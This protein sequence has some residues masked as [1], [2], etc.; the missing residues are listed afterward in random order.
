MAWNKES[1]ASRRARVAKQ[2]RD[3]HGKWIEMGGGVKWFKNGAWHNGTASAFKGNNVEVTMEDGS[4]VLVNHREIEPIRA[5][6]SL[7]EKPAKPTGSVQAKK[8][9]GKAATETMS[10]KDNDPGKRLTT[11]ADELEE[12]DEVYLHG[13]SKQSGSYGIKDSDAAAFEDRGFTL[14]LDGKGEPHR[15]RVVDTSGDKV[16]VEDS[17]GKRHEIDKNDNV[18]ADDPEVDAAIQNRD[19]NDDVPDDVDDFDVKSVDPKELGVPKEAVAAYNKGV[20]A[21]KTGDLEKAEKNFEARNGEEFSDDFTLGYLDGPHIEDRARDK[22][23]GLYHKY[24]AMKARGEK[25]AE[26]K[27]EVPVE[28]PKAEVPAKPQ[29][30]DLP[31]D[32]L[33]LTDAEKKSIND[34]ETGDEA[35]K[36][37]TESD[38]G[39]Y[40][41][42]ARSNKNKPFVDAY[43]K[44]IKD[45]TA[46]HE[47]AKDDEAPAK[48][49]KKSEGTPMEA[50]EKSMANLAEDI[51]DIKNQKLEKE[52]E[53]A[54]LAEAA[55]DVKND[56][57]EEFLL[58]AK[59]GEEEDEW[60][61]DVTDSKGN[62]V[63]TLPLEDQKPQD[64]AKAIKNSI[65]SKST[66]KDSEEPTEAPE[67]PAEK[68]VEESKEEEAP[69]TDDKSEEKDDSPLGKA[70]KDA[71]FTEDDIKK[72]ENAKDETEAEKEFF[73]SPSGKKAS[74]KQ[75]ADK[76]T[77]PEYAEARKAFE[78]FKNEKFPTGKAESDEKVKQNQEER[79]RDDKNASPEARADRAKSSI[80]RNRERDAERAAE[81][82]P[83]KKIAA[84]DR[85]IQIGEN[86]LKDAEK[87]GNEPL[88]ERLRENIDNLKE[89][90]EKLAPKDEAPAEAEAEESNTPAV[91]EPF[92]VPEGGVSILSNKKLERKTADRM[93]EGDTFFGQQNEKGDFAPV[94]ATQLRMQ[95]GAKPYTLKSVDSSTKETKWVA[96][97]SEGNEE[98][99]TWGVGQRKSHIISDSEKNRELMG[100]TRKSDKPAE[101]APASEES[102]AVEDDERVDHVDENGDVFLKDG[103]SFGSI[104][105]EEDDDGKEFMADLGSVEG[106]IFRS[107]GYYID[108][109][110]D[111]NVDGADLFTP[112]G[113]KI[114]SFMGSN[115]M[116]DDIDELADTH[117]DGNKLPDTEPVKRAKGESSS[118]ETPAEEPE[119]PK[120][121]S[122]G[123][124]MEDVETSVSDVENTLRG[125]QDR[126]N[127]DKSVIKDPEKI[128][129]RYGPSV[130]P[131]S[132]NTV[133]LVMHDGKRS[134]EVADKD[135]NV[136]GHVT[137]SGNPSDNSQD[138]LDISN[139]KNSSNEASEEKDPEEEKLAEDAEQEIDQQLETEEGSPGTADPNVKSTIGEA[140][141]DIKDDLGD[142]SWEDL[143]E[144]TWPVVG[145]EEDLF[146]GI[147][148]ESTEDDQFLGLYDSDDNELETYDMKGLV[149]DIDER[150][151]DGGDRRERDDS[152]GGELD[153]GDGSADGGDSGD[154]E[155]GGGD[156]VDP[157]EYDRQA[158]S[159]VRAVKKDLV[160]DGDNVQLD[161]EYSAEYEVDDSGNGRYRLYDSTGRTLVKIARKNEDR[162]GEILRGYSDADRE[163]HRAFATEAGSEDRKVTPTRQMQKMSSV[164]TYFENDK[165]DRYTKLNGGAW[166]MSRAGDNSDNKTMG[167]IEGHGR[168]GTSGEFT[169]GHHADHHR[170]A[171][172]IEAMSDD[173]LR[174]NLADFADRLHKIIEVDGKIGDKQ[175]SGSYAQGVRDQEAMQIYRYEAYR[176]H[177]EASDYSNALWQRLRESGAHKDG[178][179]DIGEFTPATGREPHTNKVG[180]LDDDLWTKL[181]N[182][183]VGL[184]H[185]TL[186]NNFELRSSEKPSRGAIAWGNKIDKWASSGE[187]ADDYVMYRSILASPDA[188]T[189]F[190][191]GNIV[192]D[193]GVMSLADN[194]ET[195]EH[196][197]GARTKRTA[198]KIPIMVEVQGRKGEKMT[199]A[200]FGSDELVVPRGSRMFIAS[201][202]MGEDGI[203]RVTARLNPSEA[204]VAEWTNGATSKGSD[205]PTEAPDAPEST[206]KPLTKLSPKAS[207]AET[208]AFAEE[209]WEERA[210]LTP[211]R[212]KK[213]EIVEKAT[214]DLELEQLDAEERGD[215][216]E[217]NKIEAEI[218]ALRSDLQDEVI[219]NRAERIAGGKVA[220]KSTEAELPADEPSTPVG[221]AP[222]DTPDTLPSEGMEFAKGQV[223]EHAKHGR[224]TIVRVE[225]NGEYARVNF[226]KYD[227]PKKTFGINLKKLTQTGETATL[228]NGPE[229]DTKVKFPDSSEAKVGAWSVGERV[230][231]GKHGAGVIQRLEG[232][233]EFARV[234]FDKDGDP[235]RTY[236][237]KLSKLGKGDTGTPPNGKDPSTKVDGTE[238]P[239]DKVNSGSTKTRN[240]QKNADGEEFIFG[241]NEAELYVGAVVIHP[242]FGRGRVVKLEGNGKY[243]RVIFDNDPTGIPRGIVGAKLQDESIEQEVDRSGFVPENLKKK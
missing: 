131:N 151:R 31:L 63:D 228:P 26:S 113:E 15:A 195:A 227:D 193:K 233:G 57:G 34:A 165:G 29:G 39:Q 128:R 215:F 12:G 204:E 178:A 68:P 1:K 87:K 8:S 98:E 23:Q 73:Q 176:L 28:E 97:D 202:E 54:A 41:P 10:I 65:E 158:D 81:N 220:P 59:R 17:N 206:L 183:Y 140:L 61:L 32:G 221:D 11:N 138:V 6:G 106:K 191:A 238:K 95:P 66:S 101:E 123:K 139:G 184:D 156:R 48:E 42:I 234:A 189:E 45:I 89:Q 62:V 223:V 205:A 163:L 169:L 104:P 88:A 180:P 36:R 4:K 222:S 84:L 237:V 201:S 216:V 55:Y 133:D 203:L 5:K 107:D 111:P 52:P 217:A 21:S 24:A 141:Q 117:K 64:F 118:D 115:S 181:R 231:H 103:E 148:K 240:V 171:S 35:L 80:E 25:P 164:G 33:D 173:E 230:N 175:G 208:Q 162:L 38:A 7:G 229:T 159:L 44:A 50:I 70:L 235:K 209:Y 194:R 239:K 190:S 71:G 130:I 199:A 224:G 91:G 102:M 167:V 93:K 207:N 19:D 213:F 219:A 143:K 135:G 134:W 144:R 94:K 145:A 99:F 16:V 226:D 147:G 188:A 192:T 212:A 160:D 124:P 86:F 13:R 67:T 177:D 243:A 109:P 78:D 69:K 83:E 214:E 74:D 112:D 114:G 174:D 157:A 46:K 72:I 168:W 196:Y 122:H 225:G 75:I 108:A 79:E 53:E 146:I 136:L 121:D 14:P 20:R 120:L 129:G 18:L 100:L 186:K 9:A 30:E 51:A 149:N 241:K 40:L 198:G 242:K 179:I 27:A 43:R 127:Q 37:L 155:N 92:D 126:A 125:I 200:D 85:Q 82:T 142:S 197:L 161:D 211:E 232:N 2:L 182:E 119:E 154:D 150:E 90:R 172:E 47:V 116:H 22:F 3:K 105:L 137:K 153:R 236:G 170:P 152:G 185:R 218:D 77:S 96:V 76:K 210:N 187:L 56:A 49:A 58:T 132:E 110:S 60:Q 166:G